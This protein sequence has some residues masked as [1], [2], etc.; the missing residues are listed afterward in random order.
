MSST[1]SIA[2]CLDPLSLGECNPGRRILTVIKCQ[3]FVW[4]VILR[5]ATSEDK[6]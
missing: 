3:L 6:R 5:D 4:V 2:G 1:Q